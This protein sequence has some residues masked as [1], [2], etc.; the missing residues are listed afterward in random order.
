[1][2]RL[3]VLSLLLAGSILVSGCA[4]TIPEPTPADVPRLEDARD[5]DPGNPEILTRLGMA[6]YKAGKLDESEAALI[7]ATETGQAP[8]AAYL[9]LGLA[10]ED[11][12]DWAG[13][14]EAYTSYV[15]EGRY[16]PL[17]AEIEDRLT[18]IARREL[19][20]RVE[21]ALVRESELAQTDPAP[22]SVAVFPFL[23]VSENEE[24]TPLQVALAD[25][26]TTD[27]AL[28]GALTVLERT[29]VQTL[30]D[31]MALTE[32]G[33]SSPET[34]A[35]AGRLLQA[36]H[37]IQGALTTL[38]DEDLRL[39]ADVLSTV[40]RQAAGEATG[41]DQLTRIFDLEK[42]AVFDVLDILGVALTPAE[43]EAIG[44]NR[45]E[46]LQAFL[47]Y[48]RGLMA[49]DRGDYGAA[50]QFF[51]QARQL[52]P[53]FGAA[54]EAQMEAAALE[55]AE[56]TSTAEVATR[57]LPE[58]TPPTLESPPEQDAPV[59]GTGTSS[60]LLSRTLNQ[61]AD[62]PATSMLN[63]GTTVEDNQ[64]KNRDPTTESKGQEGVTTPT[65]AS[66]SITIRR[67]GGGS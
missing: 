43:R 12:E 22:G 30:L 35:R 40:R 46:N 51:N 49:L 66:I 20:A 52:D 26:M 17:K 11:Q 60:N 8:G 32:A 9:Y 15:R 7:Q 38:T 5:R 19:K 23:L 59:P 67:P 58:L 27:L 54:Q 37:V 64:F 39:D 1:M 34:G 42:E 47:A 24:L 55:G 6:H 4:G 31:E 50:V 63:Q 45:T 56:E 48:G 29:Q 41:Q 61:V 21:A 16:G 13:A 10:R 18:Y 25:M 14:R 28:S 65:T 36:E 53:G 33:F 2:K 44:A 57:T 62:N 3:Y